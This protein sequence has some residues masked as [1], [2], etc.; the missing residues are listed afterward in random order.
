[1]FD[2]VITAAKIVGD[3][4]SAMDVL[5]HIEDMGNNRPGEVWVCH[6]ETSCV[7]WNGE[8]KKPWTIGRSLEACFTFAKHYLGSVSECLTEHFHEQ[9]QQWA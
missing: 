7:V 3:K 6:P 1:M 9:K 2:I 5:R 4:Q 8:V